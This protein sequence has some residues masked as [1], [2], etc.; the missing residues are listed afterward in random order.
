MSDL[1]RA[2]GPSQARDD[3]VARRPARLVDH[4]HAARRA[5]PHALTR[6]RP[7]AAR[8][9]PGRASAGSRRGPA[10]SAARRGSRRPPTRRRSPRDRSAR[11]R[12]SSTSSAPAASPSGSEQRER[13]RHGQ[14]GD[15]ERSRQVLDARE[16]RVGLLAA[17]D[18]HGHD[19]RARAQAELHEPAAPEALELVA[20]LEELADALHPLREHGDERVRDRAGARRSPGTRARRR[21]GCVKLPRNG[22]WKMTSSASQRTSRRRGCSRRTARRSIIPSN[23]SVP[24]WFATSRQRPSAGTCSTPCTST[25][26]YFVVE[27]IE[28]RQDLLLVDRVVAELV[29]LLGAVAQAHAAPLAQVEVGREKLARRVEHALGRRRDRRPASAAAPSDGAAS[30]SV[31]SSLRLALAARAR[32]SSGRAA[33]RARGCAPRRRDRSADRRDRARSEAAPGRSCS[34]AGRRRVCAAPSPAAS[35][36][37]PRAGARTR[38]GPRAAARATAA[39]PT[40]P[41]ATAACFLRVMPC[42]P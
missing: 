38:R 16:H 26:K 4:Q 11:R 35:V 15:A 40:R 5:G 14:V 42:S 1:A 7:I 10:R 27:E 24:E 18:G 25:R 23:G 31:V 22:K 33:P 39:P 9:A 19:R 17:D 36:P 29:D 12:R 3:V 41:S 6:T 28:E 37:P 20:L 30:A 2:E 34:L 32:R 8:A 13:R 21:C